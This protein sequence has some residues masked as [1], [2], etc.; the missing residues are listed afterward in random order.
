MTQGEQSQTH[1]KK[2]GHELRFHDN[3]SPAGVICWEGGPQTIENRL[4][5]RF[6][7]RSAGEMLLPYSCKSICSM[8]HSWASTGH[9]LA[10][11]NSLADSRRNTP[12]DNVDGTFRD[13]PSP[14]NTHGLPCGNSRS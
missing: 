11:S 4:Q 13:Q 5:D 6:K 10:A 14:R 2:E 12:G 9:G 8:S 7:T 1:H 3:T